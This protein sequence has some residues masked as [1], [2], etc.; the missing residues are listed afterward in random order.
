MM[1]H[2][3]MQGIQMYAGL[4]V[5]YVRG[6]TGIGSNFGRG[7]GTLIGGGIGLKY[8]GEGLTY[9][10]VYT[11]AIKSPAFVTKTRGGFYITIGFAM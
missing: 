5:G 7:E 2:D 1:V 11:R 10:M 4:D 6:K 9:D 8:Y 3:S